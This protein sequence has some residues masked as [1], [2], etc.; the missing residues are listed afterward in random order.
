MTREARNKQSRI[1]NR[2]ANVTH[3]KKQDKIKKAKIKQY[4]KQKVLYQIE[5]I[6][7][8]LP[9]EKIIDKDKSN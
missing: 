8:N 6:R 3:K 4:I 1:S 2:Q 9:P 5:R 7:Q